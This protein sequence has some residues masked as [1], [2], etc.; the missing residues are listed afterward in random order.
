MEAVALIKNEYLGD[1]AVT[2]A[3]ATRTKERFVESLAKKCLKKGDYRSWET[4]D[5]G[6]LSQCIS[7]SRLFRSVDVVL[8]AAELKVTVNERWTLIPVPYVYSSN[9][10]RAAGLFIFESNLL[11]YGK[12]VSA[13]GSVAT[14][15][16]SF[17]LMYSDPA[18]NFSDH[19]LFVM[20][21]R[22]KH[23]M[24]TNLTGK[25]QNSLFHEN[26]KI[27]PMG[28]A[29]RHINVASTLAELAERTIESV[30]DR[31]RIDMRLARVREALEVAPPLCRGEEKE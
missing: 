3:G 27:Q 25:V 18:V 7:N 1:I 22:M 24:K 17:S 5:A 21:F 29:G 9:D 14:E 15:G 6:A 28:K 20:A 26:D 31:V 2:V 16:N 8:G 4:V 10:K 12:T 13:G 19:T 30:H 11:G 23:S